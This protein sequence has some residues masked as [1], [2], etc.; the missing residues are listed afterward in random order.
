MPVTNSHGGDYGFLAP[1]FA[2]H[3]NDGK[4]RRRDVLRLAGG[5]AAL[6]AAFKLARAQA[7]PAHPIKLLVGFPP[8]GQVDIIARIAAHQIQGAAGR[9]RRQRACAVARGVRQIHC[10]RNRKVAQGGPVRGIA[11]AVRVFTSPRPRREGDHAAFAPHSFLLAIAAPSLS[12]RNFAQTIESTTVGSA[13]T[14]VPKPQ[15]TPAM[16]RSRP[17]MSA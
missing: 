8:G 5:V 6:P 7:F 4:L 12:A 17:T 14:A 3:R 11:A 1:R 9:S 10:R 15:S 13:R 2:R 16:T